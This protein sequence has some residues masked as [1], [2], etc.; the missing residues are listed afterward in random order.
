MCIFRPNR[1]GQQGQNRQSALAITLSWT[2][3]A[4]VLQFRIPRQAVIGGLV[5]L[6]ILLL[7]LVYGAATFGRLSSE[8]DA[9]KRLRADNLYLRRQLNRMAELEDRVVGLD[10]TRRELLWVVGV[11]E[12]AHG[13]MFEARAEMDKDAPSG[14]YRHVEPGDSPREEDLVELRRVLTRIPLAGPHTR[15]FGPVGDTGVF[16][17][18][19]DIAGDTGATVWASGEGIVSFVGLD[20]TFGRVLVITHSLNIETMYGHNTRILVQVGDFVIPGQKIAEVGNTGQSTAPHLHFETRWKGKAIDPAMVFTAWQ[21]E[22][23][24]RNEEHRPT[25]R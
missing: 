3:G 10:A 1:A 8:A 23:T 20:E 7:V 18:G 14:T 24:V 5:L 25:A 13:T 19:L 16:H 22:P 6:G 4:R 9:A 2:T 21:R 11:E 15:G 12:P 17:I